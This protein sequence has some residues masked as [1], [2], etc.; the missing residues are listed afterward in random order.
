MLLKVNIRKLKNNGRLC[1]FD[2][3]HG[4]CYDFTENRKVRDASTHEISG[5][6]A[7]FHYQKNI[8]IE[9]KIIH[10]GKIPAIMNIK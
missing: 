8:Q 5:R 2:I 1:E 10:Q 7:P 4:L 9:A 6:F 3:I